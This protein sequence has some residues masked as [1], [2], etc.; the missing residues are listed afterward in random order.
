[1]RTTAGDAGAVAEEYAEKGFDVQTLRG[2]GKTLIYTRR[3]VTEV[4]IDGN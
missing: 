1:M 3:V 4:V 2:D